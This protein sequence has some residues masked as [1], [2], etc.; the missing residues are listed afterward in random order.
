MVQMKQQTM[1]SCVN[2]WRDVWAWTL[3]LLTCSQSITNALVENYEER[4]LYS[5][6]NY[7]FLS[8]FTARFSDQNETLFWDPGV[9]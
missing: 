7:S 6:P 5:N 3:P 9:Q 4:V 8:V 1:F 2:K